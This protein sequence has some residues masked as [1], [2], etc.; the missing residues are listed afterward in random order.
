M[1]KVHLENGKDQFTLN[2][3]EYVYDGIYKIRSIASVEW[4]DKQG[5]LVGNDY[6]NF[7]RIP[8]WMK[9]YSESEWEKIPKVAG[10]SHKTVEKP[11]STTVNSKKLKV[12]PLKELIARGTIIIIQNNIPI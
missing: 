9:S 3:R 1:Y 6:T 5:V 7:I 2:Y 10:T 12:T 11:L 8:D 4:F